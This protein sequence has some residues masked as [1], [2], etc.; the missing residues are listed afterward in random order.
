MTEQN[1]YFNILTFDWPKAN[2]SF[3]FSKVENAFCS[4]I[5]KTLFPKNIESIFPGIL[6]DGTEF[7]Y[8]T[9]DYEKEGFTPLSIQFKTENEDL[10]RKYYNRQIRYYFQKIRNQIVRKGFIGQNQV[11]VKS[12]KLSNK[13]FNIYL[14]F[15]LKVQFR[16]VS[17]YPELL[18]SYDGKSKVFKKDIPALVRQVSPSLFKKVIKGNTVCRFDDVNTEPNADLR[19]VFPALNFAL[20]KALKIEPDPIIKG[21]RYK[22]YLEVLNIFKD[23]F[24]SKQEF[25][26]LIPLHADDFYT[27]PESLI[28]YVEDQSNELEFSNHQIGRTPKSDFRK[29]KPF[30]GTD[31]KK[32]HLFFIYHVDDQSTKDKLKTYFEKGLAHYRGLYDYAGILFHTD[33]SMT[34]CFQN[35]ENPYPEIQNFF[36]TPTHSLASDVKYLAIYLTPFSKEETRRQEER[37]YI[38]VKELL[39]NRDIACQFVEP[40]TVEAPNDNFKWSLTTMSV[41]ILAKLGGIPWRLPTPIQKELIVGVGA[42]KHPDD[43]Q[44]VSSAISFDNSGHFNEFDYFMRHETNLLAGSIATKVREFTEKFDSPSRLIIHF[45][46]RLS[47]EELKP[48]EKAL[49][50]LKLS[51]PLPIFIITINKTEAKDIVAFDDKWFNLMPYSGTYINIGNKKYLLFN[52]SRHKN[53]N[54]FHATDGFPFP[55]KLSIDCNDKKQLENEATINQLIDQVYQFSRMYWKSLAQ[56]SLPVTVKYPEMIAEIAPYMEGNELPDNAKNN[57]W[58]L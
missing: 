51:K 53:N 49:Q 21:N 18:V 47:E 29:L 12:A 50:E 41:T 56:Q 32:I 38:K 35:R 58:F 28:H 46:K 42:F 6:E 8:S 9:F 15:S 13:Q 26:D 43:V 11:W 17:D 3:Y 23:F 5:H 20:A 24:L 31:H 55:I 27:V 48:I 14:K 22:S 52:S 44:Y 34:I 54:S 2:L 4:R 40:A 36:D 33:E 7:I 57:L 1:L 30:R 10:L 19:K 25:K 37:V 16:N 45:Y 39:L